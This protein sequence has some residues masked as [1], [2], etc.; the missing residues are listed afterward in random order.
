MS[1]VENLQPYTHCK[2]TYT[3]KISIY[4]FTN[5]LFY[6]LFPIP[7]SQF[8]TDLSQPF[9]FFPGNSFSMLHMV[10]LKMELKTNLKIKSRF[11][12]PIISS[13]SKIGIH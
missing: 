4:F 5:C 9:N 12:M 6:L 8:F 7:T 13:I 11:L 10:T 1:F 3:W 2:L